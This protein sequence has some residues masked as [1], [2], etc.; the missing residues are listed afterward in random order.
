MRYICTCI[1]INYKCTCMHTITLVQHAP[2]IPMPIPSCS[3]PRS[4]D[5]KMWENQNRPRRVVLQSTRVHACQSS[6][7]R[8]TGPLQPTLTDAS[9]FYPTQPMGS[10][11]EREAGQNGRR[12]LACCRI[13]ETGFWR[14]DCAHP[15]WGGVARWQRPAQKTSCWLL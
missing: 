14:A 6:S 13:P 9:V 15:G 12:S 1:L 4:P 10:H 2:S 3:V 7:P 5:T 8:D 11:C